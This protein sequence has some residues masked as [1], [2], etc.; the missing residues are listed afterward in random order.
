MGTSV[1]LIDVLP[2]RCILT[3]Y[4]I[5]DLTKITFMFENKLDLIILDYLMLN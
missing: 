5:Y 4:T 3:T 2:N 1:N